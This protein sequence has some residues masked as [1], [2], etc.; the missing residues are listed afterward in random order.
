MYT[1]ER[2]LNNFFDYDIP[3]S[4][5]FVSESSNKDGFMQKTFRTKDNRIKIV[6]F[7]KIEDENTEITKLKNE[8]EKSIREQRFED[9][10]IFRD[11]INNLMKH[12]NKLQILEEQKTIAIEEQ[13][14]EKAI[15]LRDQINKLKNQK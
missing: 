7:Q 14:F 12:R 2:L 9:S 4:D 5:L 3:K 6:L 13:N 8:L 11:K 10:I 1:L 15:E